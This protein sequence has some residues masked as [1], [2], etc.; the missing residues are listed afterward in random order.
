MHLHRVNLPQRP[1]TAVLRGGASVLVLAAL[2]ALLPAVHP[3][4]RPV[5][6]PPS[7]LLWFAHVFPVALIGYL[8]GPR[9]ALLAVAA[10]VLAV[11]AGRQPGH[12]PAYRFGC[13]L[14]RPPRG[15][16]AMV[17]YALTLLLRRQLAV[18]IE[19]LAGRAHLAVAPPL[20]PLGIRFLPRGPT[21]RPAAETTTGWLASNGLEQGVAS[22]SQWPRRHQA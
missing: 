7:H 2:L 1:V 22:P 21:D 18:H 16:V 11:A 13:A 15:A 8:R 6:G 14:R 3:A 20:G 17:L 4:L 10:S 9:A 19:R 12:R 5:L